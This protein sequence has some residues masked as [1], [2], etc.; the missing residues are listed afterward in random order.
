MGHLLAEKHAKTEDC[1]KGN[2]NHSDDGRN[3]TEVPPA[4]YTDKR[5][6]NK[7]EKDCH[8]K[9]DEDWASEIED[10]PLIPRQLPDFAVSL[11]DLRRNFLQ[12]G[13]CRLR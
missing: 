2:E 13:E 3:T 8:S 7:G 4:Q 1:K 5:C 11:A 12:F 9:W 6:E 10:L